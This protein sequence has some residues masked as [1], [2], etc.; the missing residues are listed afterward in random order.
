METQTLEHTNIATAEITSSNAE[1]E[2][3]FAGLEYT[4]QAI[5]EKPRQR[6]LLEIYG[7]HENSD[8]I[9]T[10]ADAPIADEPARLVFWHNHG[11]L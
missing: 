6:R 8:A 11:T 7:N 3:F 5:R 4:A 2:A 10:L 9:H 1:V